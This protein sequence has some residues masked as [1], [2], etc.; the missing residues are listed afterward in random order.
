MR[1]IHMFKD[2]DASQGG[3]TPQPS[4]MDLDNPD[5]KPA[6]PTDPIKPLI[7]EGGPVEG[8]DDDGNLLDGFEKNADG[9][10]TKIEAPVEG[11][12]ADGN[13]LDGF[14]K[15]ADGNIVPIDNQGNDDNP[16]AAEEFWASV[17]NLTGTKVD[18]DY[19]D[20][21][22]ISPEGVAL[23]ETALITQTEKNFD[24][25]LRNS[26]PRAYA[27]FLHTQQGG[28]DEEFLGTGKPTITDKE[29]FETNLD[30]QANLVKQDLLN[31]GVPVEV[32]EATVASYIK[33]NE[34]TT[35]ALAVY[36]KY[37][38]D[39][40]KQVQFLENQ[41]KIEQANFVA[42][43]DSLEASI[44]NT[45]TQGINLAIP[46]TKKAGFIEFVK[47]QTRYADKEFFIVQQIKQDTLKS[48]LEGLYFQ[49]M[50][51][52]LKS[53]VAKEAKE[54]TVKRLRANVA[55]DKSK[56]PVVPTVQK[57][58]LNVPLGEI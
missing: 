22:P 26:N 5:F 7:P 17:E 3:G 28:S 6:E 25:Y 53:L 11:L 4:L 38:E 24:E 34:L 43:R 49:Y 48:Q 35:K 1:L 45:I 46:E 16:D 33:T 42:Q 20:V 58:K 29:T 18:V 21:D 50:N 31:K 15:A 39:D 8:L 12:D 14:E 30:A 56:L 27:Y 13:L 55:A 23:R 52:N 57:P 47:N 19:G 51:G 36:D 32:V 40:K 10:I 54:Q 41:Q 44:V 2:A 37:L 9:T